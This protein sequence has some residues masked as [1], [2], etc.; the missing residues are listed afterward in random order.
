MAKNKI[1]LL[2]FLL[3]VG[4]TRSA[5]KDI[6]HIEEDAVVADT[7]AGENTEIEIIEVDNSEPDFVEIISISDVDRVAEIFRAEIGVRE[8]TG[9]NDGPRV[10]EYLASVELG[11]GYAWCAAFVTWTFKQAEIDA[12]VSAWSPSWF[13]QKNVIYT[14]GSHTNRTPGTADVFGI[15]FQNLGRIAHVGFIDDWENGDFCITVEGNTNDEGPC[16][17]DGVYRKRRL[18]SQIYKISRWI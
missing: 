16:D 14:H 1:I 2:C 13:P 8:L 3:F 17:G 18:K 9:K 12:A 15:Y 11:K 5:V 10:E 7:V 6:E 4:C